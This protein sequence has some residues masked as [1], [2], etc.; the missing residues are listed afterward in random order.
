[1]SAKQYLSYKFPKNAPVDEARFAKAN[2]PTA[3]LRGADGKVL[4]P[5]A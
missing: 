4:I 3:I 5:V 2:A 1:M